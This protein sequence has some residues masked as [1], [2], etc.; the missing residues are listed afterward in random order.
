MLSARPNKAPPPT[1]F[2]VLGERC[3]GTNY[4]QAFLRANFDLK[5]GDT[6]GWKHGFPAFL[7]APSDLL[8]VVIT[9]DAH[10]WCRSLFAKPWHSEHALRKLS[11]SEFIRA[12]WRSKADG[13]QYFGFAP[14]DTRVGQPL[15]ADRHP[16]T[17]RRF[18]N[19]LQMRNVK[20]A[21][22]LG[23]LSRD[24]NVAI[25]RHEWLVASPREVVDQLAETFNLRPSGS[26]TV[27]EAHFGWAPWPKRAGTMPKPPVP[28]LEEDQRFINAELDTEIEAILGYATSAG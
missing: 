10:D 19:I 13:A 9:R 3:S 7:A 24:M 25:L 22:W 14:E 26:L 27:P 21:A 28:L 18:T 17:G 20:N 23:L 2:Q 4:L 5:P 6:L 15:Q 8:A 16:I 1:R 11:F 12:E